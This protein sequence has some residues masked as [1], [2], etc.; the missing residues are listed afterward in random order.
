MPEPTFV[1][2]VQHIII[3]DKTPQKAWKNLS[4]C[5]IFRL[6]AASSGTCATQYKP[7]KVNAADSSHRRIHATKDSCEAAIPSH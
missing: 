5:P 2:K 7:G 1:C 4:H 3:P 6:S